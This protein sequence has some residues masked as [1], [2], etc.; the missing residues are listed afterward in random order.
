MVTVFPRKEKKGKKIAICTT[1]DTPKFFIFFFHFYVNF[2]TM[3]G[4]FN[5]IIQTGDRY[6]NHEKTKS[7]HK[8]SEHI[9]LSMPLAIQGPVLSS[10]LTEISS[11]FFQKRKRKKKYHP[12]IKEHIFLN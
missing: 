12:L 4:G 8:P 3:L 1:R 9:S 11:V 2:I 6:L 10:L 7:I 5:G